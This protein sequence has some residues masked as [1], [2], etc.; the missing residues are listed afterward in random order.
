MPGATDLHFN[1][2]APSFVTT[3]REISARNRTVVADAFP[4]HIARHEKLLDALY[5]FASAHVWTFNIT[6]TVPTAV[7]KLVFSATHKNLIALFGML[8]NTMSGLLGPIRPLFRQVME[9]QI[10]AKYVSVRND[11]ALAERWLKQEHL[12][13]PRVVLVHMHDAQARALAD[14]WKLTH[15]FVHASTGS[16]QVSLNAESNIHM[17]AHDLTV[18]GLL[19]H[20]Q[21][22]VTTQHTFDGQER[23]LAQAY[24]TRYAKPGHV[25]QLRRDMRNDLSIDLKEHGKDV[26]RFIRVFRSQWRTKDGTPL[27]DRQLSPK[28]RRFRSRLA[29]LLDET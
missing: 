9:G 5:A 11:E 6:R 7:Q 14:M 13:V 8:D 3:A 12:S 18:M 25:S 22:H 28:L 17:V 1:N 24:E 2:P 15:V 4:T 29:N 21:H 20:T 19:L 23:Y 26:R 10:L 16:Q 27:R